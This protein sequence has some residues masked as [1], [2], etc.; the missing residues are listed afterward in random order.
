MDWN[1]V[2]DAGDVDGGI[3]NVVVEIPAGS[4]NKIEWKRNL[5][6]FTIDRV[7][8]KIFAKP[9]NYGFIPQ[10]L[11]EDGDELDAL[12]ITDE[13]LPTG[14]YLEA[15]IIGVMRFVD[16]G[17][18]DDKVVVV[19]ADDRSTGNAIKTLADLPEQTIKQIEHHFTHYKDLK[20][21]GSTVVK[22]W[23]DIETAKQIIRESQERWTNQ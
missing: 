12:I 19:P 6:V 5:K 7:E 3:I 16:D 4:N 8:P 23:E 22:G 20:K 11:D 17:E 9:T 21:P 18:V 10:T 15:R 14:V 1:Q 2:L 13:P